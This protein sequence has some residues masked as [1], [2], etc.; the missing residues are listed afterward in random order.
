MLNSK[1]DTLHIEMIRAELHR[2]REVNPRS[3]L[4]GFA[5]SLKLHP[6]ALS[7]IL[8]GKQTLSVEAAKFV[9]S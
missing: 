9:L 3:S 1:T 5:A 7:R 2:R 4:R 8:S 6:S